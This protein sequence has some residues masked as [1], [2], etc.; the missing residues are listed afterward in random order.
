MK[1][2]ILNLNCLF[3]SKKSD[4]TKMLGKLVQ[5]E[6]DDLPVL[7]SSN[8]DEKSTLDHAQNKRTQVRSEVPK[9]TFS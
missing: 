2:R 3:L 9:E 1:T 8:G 4:L 6:Q 5:R 7:S